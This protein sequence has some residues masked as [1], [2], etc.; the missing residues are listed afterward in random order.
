ML[1]NDL[2]HLVGPVCESC[3]AAY[4]L[5]VSTRHFLAVGEVSWSGNITCIDGISN[6]DIQSLFR[7]GRPKAPVS[8]Q[9]WLRRSTSGLELSFSLTLCNLS[10]RST[11]HFAS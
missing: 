2:T 3:D 6:D 10:L 11:E 5:A 7:G 4:K 8:Y 1:A 9:H